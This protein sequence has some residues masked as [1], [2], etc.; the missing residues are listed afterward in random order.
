[1]IS[2]RSTRSPEASPV[3]GASPCHTSPCPA[4]RYAFSG[5]LI[6]LLL[7]FMSV[8]AQ[9]QRFGQVEET[10]SNIDSYY[11]YVQPGAATIEI[12]VMGTVRNPG[13]Y[14]LSEGTD[15]G[16]LLALAGGPTLDVRLRSR[17]RTATVRLYRPQAQG[18]ALLYEAE[19]EQ[20]LAAE[21]ENYPA[22]QDGD[23]LTVE[24]TERQR[25]VW[26]DLFTIAN[27]VAVIA[28]A[29]ERLAFDQ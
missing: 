1:M 14:R 6:G 29:I 12:K 8:E 9:A 16:Q 21:S 11:Y 3:P 25:L 5:V 22:L 24:V 18:Q 23:I 10:E 28:L 19:F 26:R 15:L 17:P 20:N 4:V 7:S 2:S 27:T 13:L